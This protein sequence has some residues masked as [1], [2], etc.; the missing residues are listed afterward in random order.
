[1]ADIQHRCALS[2]VTT[3]NWSFEQDLEGYARAG[4]AGI[5]VWLNKLEGSGAGYDVLPVRPLDPARVE[6][7][8]RLI[9]R[10]GLRVPGLIACGDYTHAD[11][12]ERR[13]HVEHTIASIGAAAHLGAECLCICPGPLRGLSREQATELTIRSLHETL[14]A[15]ERHG[16]RLAVEPLHPRHTDFINT[17]AQAQALIEEIDHPLCG[18]FV[19][20]YQ[21]WRSDDLL[22]AITRAADHIMAVHVADSRP[23]PRS[24]EDRLVPGDGVIPLREI[25]DAVK[26]TGYDGWYT[27]EIMSDELWGSDYDQLARRCLDRLCH[28]LE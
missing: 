21:L 12:G 16:V 22:P 15:A 1:M 17:L 27:I 18:L 23:A 13:L 25:L 20:T 7:A 26:K 10:A 6:Q 5:E 4:W 24:V 11:A 2:E 14:P 3:T 28:I 9:E 19:D 8:R